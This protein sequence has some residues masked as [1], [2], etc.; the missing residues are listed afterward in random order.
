[1]S[2][3]AVCADGH[4]A[5]A[6]HVRELTSESRCAAS[7]VH[8]FSSRAR[9]R[10][11]TYRPNNRSWSRARARHTRCVYRD[12]IDWASPGGW[13]RNRRQRVAAWPRPSSRHATAW[14]G[15]NERALRSSGSVRWPVLA[16]RRTHQGCRDQGHDR[17]R[18]RLHVPRHCCATR[19]RSS[20]ASCC[21]WHV[22]SH[23]GHRRW[24]RILSRRRAA[25]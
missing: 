25:G 13:R 8:Q 21:P 17:S 10:Y 11:G 19:R 3:A 20:A 12:P 4:V 16:Y 1:M 14:S 24:P 6:A 5:V 23:I 9:Q 18:C 2:G 7:G 22:S 15:W